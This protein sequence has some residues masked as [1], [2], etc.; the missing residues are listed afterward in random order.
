MK[1]YVQN[2]NMSFLFAEINQLRFFMSDSFSI[3]SEFDVI[4]DK[5]KRLL[6]TLV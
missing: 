1:I 4:Y 2:K 6:M 3:I 5:K